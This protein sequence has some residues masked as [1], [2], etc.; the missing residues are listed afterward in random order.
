MQNDDS[1]M[2]DEMF[3]H[4]ELKGSTCNRYFFLQRKRVDIKSL[5]PSD[6]T[7]PAIEMYI[8]LKNGALNLAFVMTLYHFPDK[9]NSENLQIFIERG[10]EQVKKIAQKLLDKFD[11]HKSAK[12]IDFLAHGLSAC[13]E[14]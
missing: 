11:T 3:S 2:I 14:A 10:C 1:I 12:E 6:N 7:W 8:H 13:I 9:F 5:R 4:A